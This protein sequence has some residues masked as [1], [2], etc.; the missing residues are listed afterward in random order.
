MV[1]DAL[2]LIDEIII[3]QLTIITPQL[4]LLMKSISLPSYF[5]KMPKMSADNKSFSL[6]IQSDGCSS[7]KL[8]RGS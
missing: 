8:Y 6:A 5:K 2:T 3:P 7:L 1:S 4:M